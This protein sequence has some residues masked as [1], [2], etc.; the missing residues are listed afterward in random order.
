MTVTVTALLSYPNGNGGT[1]GDVVVYAC[2]INGC[3]RQLMTLIRSGEA[4]ALTA[5]PCSHRYAGRP[6]E[7]LP[8]P[9]EHRLDA[10][11]LAEWR[12]GFEAIRQ[13]QRR[14]RRRKKATTLTGAKEQR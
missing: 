5:A 11:P 14:T 10:A 9:P 4:S 3:D 2:P 12:K 7:V 13:S 8:P 6:V 1:P